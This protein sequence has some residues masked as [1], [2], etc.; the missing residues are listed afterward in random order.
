[1]R[2]SRVVA[3]VGY[4]GSG[5]TQVIEA[6]TR[7]LTARGYR[8]GTVKHVADLGFS[9]DREGRDT[10]RHAKAGADVV[11]CLASKEFARIEKRR[12]EFGELAEELR[13]QDFFLL[14]GFRELQN[15]ARIAVLRSPEEAGELINEFTIAC[16]GTSVENFPS[17]SPSQ[18][19]RLTDLVEEKAFPLLPELD[20]QRCGFN[21]C[22]DFKRAVVSG[23]ARWNG[24]ASLTE[25]AKLHVNG[26]RVHLNPFVQDLV[27]RLVQALAASLKGG[28]GKRITIEVN[29]NE[30]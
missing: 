24:C 28:E 3:I 4:K 23:S 5:K 2:S 12:V 6:L 18:A 11:I 7:E 1:L 16:V 10:W 29:L 15:V 13:G 19:S 26:R 17:F 27:A 21:S 30:R 25:L 14:E 9:I 8:V 22:A 20:C